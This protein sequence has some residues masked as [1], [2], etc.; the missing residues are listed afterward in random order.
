MV[1]LKALKYMKDAWNKVTPQT[2]TNCFRK[3]GFRDDIAETIDDSDVFVVGD[4]PFE[5][6][7]QQL[8]LEEDQDQFIMAD[9]NLTTSEPLTDDAMI[10]IVHQLM[11]SQKATAKLTIRENK[12]RQSHT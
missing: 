4:P 2:V 12:K 3:D 11:W 5:T 6:L 9:V 1:L 7:A 10:S 8:G